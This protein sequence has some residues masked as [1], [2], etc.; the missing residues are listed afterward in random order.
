MD[1]K[2]V[3]KI[4]ALMRKAEDPATPEAERENIID[5]V[6]YLMTKHGIEQD[7]LNVA[8]NKPFEA[9]HRKFLIDHYANSMA[10]LLNNICMA[11]GCL[12]VDTRRQENNRVSVFGTDEDIERVF[13]LYHSLKL[14]MLTGLSQSQD[15]KPANMHGKTWNSSFVHGFVTMVCMRIKQAA[16]RAREDLKRENE[17]TGMEVVLASKY[18]NVLSLLLSVFPNL[19]I[20][21][22]SMRSRSEAAYGH[23]RAAGQRADLGGERISSTHAGRRALG[24]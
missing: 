8:Q 2:W 15:H 11:F 4:E 7:M 3:E 14:Q 23:G 10:L 5:K 19:R 21:T 12:L 18:D 17:G 16:A 24:S 20:N 9:K 22:S 6:T 13:M 1:N